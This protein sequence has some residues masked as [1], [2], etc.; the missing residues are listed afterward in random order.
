MS[1]LITG[2]TGFIGRRLLKKLSEGDDVIALT[3]RD[4]IPQHGTKRI[5]CDLTDERSVENAICG[6]KRIDVVYHLA[7]NLDESDKNVYRENVAMTKNLIEACRK[8]GVKQLIFLS[9]IGVLGESFQPLKEDD[10]Y[11]PET[12]YEKSKRD[13]ERIIMNSGINYTIVR[14]PVIAGP[15]RFWKKIIDAAK[16]GYPLVGSGENYFH[17]A[18]ID[19]VI[20]LLLLVKNN[21]RCFNQIFH[22]ACK[23][24]RT[25][26]ETYE[27]ILKYLSVKRKMVKV[28]KIFVLTLSYL[29]EFA[30]KAL[31]KRPNVTLMSSSI[32]RLTRNRIVSTE[33]V[34]TLLNFEPKFTTEEAIRKTVEAILSES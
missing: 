30:C 34:K 4:C 9:S 22:I 17:I 16:R 25:Y 13:C 1:V 14:A 5:K 8:K 10:P 31:G 20:E 29:Y 7:A 27:L 23:D 2:S 24:A 28:P 33:K 21:E 11:N 15:N 32:K 26:R 19:D 3:R 12:L 18:Y 6:L